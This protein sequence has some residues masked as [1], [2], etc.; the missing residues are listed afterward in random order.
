MGKWGKLYDFLK[1][2]LKYKSVK[3]KKKKDGKHKKKFFYA[4]S[5]IW[6]SLHHG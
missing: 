1:T 6:G 3:G 4:Q 5:S 2:I